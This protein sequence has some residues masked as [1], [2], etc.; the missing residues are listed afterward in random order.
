MYKGLLS[1]PLSVLGDPAL[2]APSSL[3]LEDNSAEKAAGRHG[4]LA[5]IQERFEAMELAERGEKNPGALASRLSARLRLDKEADTELGDEPSTELAPSATSVPN[6]LLQTLLRHS[7]D[8]T[9]ASST[10]T[11]T[12]RELMDSVPSGLIVES[13]WQDL[14][15]ACVSWPRSLRLTSLRLTRST[16]RRGEWGRRCARRAQA[17]EGEKLL[18][19]RLPSYVYHLPHREPSQIPNVFLQTCLRSMPRKVG[20]G[21][22]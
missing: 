18:T 4:R 5:E 8:G 7:R 2:A 22:L 17:D 16:G 9:F 13:E 14:L 20:R 12:P 11:E 21:M 19:S 3:L 6:Q 15:L 1:A 10:S